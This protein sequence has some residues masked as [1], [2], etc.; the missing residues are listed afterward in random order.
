LD[1]LL[2]NQLLAVL[3]FNIGTANV[4]LININCNSGTQLV[5]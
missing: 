1:T 2:V 5:Y 3:G 4:T